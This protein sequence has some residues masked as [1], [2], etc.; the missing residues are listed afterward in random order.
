MKEQD[1]E[2]LSQ[3]L[4]GELRGSAAQALRERLMAEPPLRA[5]LE[6]L[7]MINNRI[8]EAFD[9]P[10]A[11]AVPNHISKLLE[12][13]ARQA[14][15]QRRKTWGFAVAASLVAATG[16]LMMPDQGDTPNP[17]VPSDQLI[18]HLLEQAP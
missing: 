4:D 9:F 17:Q 16:L 3:Y 7:Q 15:P 14:A 13:P 1:Y 10:G 18:A 12:E 2:L 8:S 11:D 6:R 5:E